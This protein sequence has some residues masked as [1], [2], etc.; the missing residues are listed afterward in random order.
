MLPSQRLDGVLLRGDRGIDPEGTK[1]EYAAAA[2]A[3]R[4]TEAWGA[5]AAAT[6]HDRDPVHLDSL[7]LRW[8]SY[9]AADS[10]WWITLGRQGMAAGPVISPAGYAGRYA[11]APLAQRMAF[12]QELGD[13]GVQFGWRDSRLGLDLALDLGVWRGRRFPGS[14]EGNGERPALSVHA[15]ARQEAWSIDAALLGFEPRQR[16]VNT[17][18][19][20]DH[21][22]KPPPCLP[23]RRD[24]LCF[25]G[26][27]L[28][29]GGSL[30]WT[31]TEMAT[32]WPVTLTAAGWLRDER[33]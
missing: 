15:G 11:F 31:G 23:A 6:A 13:D 14:R 17:S 3:W 1:I 25:D 26:R 33:G 19:A 29:A 2:L 5:Y 27:V 32:P 24:V 4:V 8:H 7:W 21:S 28:L 12:D 10:A 20:L 16:G 9:S 30:R 18:P 22:H